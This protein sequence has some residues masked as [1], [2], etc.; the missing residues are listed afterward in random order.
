MRSIAANQIVLINNAVKTPG[1]KPNLFI[2][3]GTT[4]GK[5]RTPN[6]GVAATNQRNIISKQQKYNQNHSDCF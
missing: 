1:A 3:N 4:I 2:V 5:I 6:I